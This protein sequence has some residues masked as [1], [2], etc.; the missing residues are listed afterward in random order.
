MSQ[1]S[2]FLHDILQLAVDIELECAGVYE[3]FAK[4]SGSDEE[5]VAFWRLYAEAERYHAATIRIHQ[6]TF[7]ESLVDGDTFPVEVEESRVFL[8]QL[9]SWREEYSRSKPALVRM[10]D[11]RGRG[12]YRV[13]HSRAPW[14]Y[15]V[16]RAL[17]P[18][19]RAL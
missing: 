10:F 1:G 8:G 12:L 19:C 18:I 16:L 14:P 6:T 3:V 9:R 5:L 4:Q 2:S 13:S 17:S 15:A 11:V 7:H